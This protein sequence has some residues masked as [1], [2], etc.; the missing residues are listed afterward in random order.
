MNSVVGGASERPPREIVIRTV[1]EDQLVEMLRVWS[2]S[3][4]PA[5]PRGRDAIENLRIQRKAA[6]D[7][8]LAA[9]EGDRMVGVVLASDDGRKG[10]INRLAVVPGARRRRVG[11]SLVEACEAAL[12]R[13]G[14]GIFCIMIEGENAASETLF[15]DMDYKRENDIVYYAKRGSQDL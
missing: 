5:R 7:L 3:G 1:E 14:R 15:Q 11:R 4:L 12:R 8:F 9:F 6:P 13:R 10:W 2:E